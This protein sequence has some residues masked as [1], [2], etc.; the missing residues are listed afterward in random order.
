MLFTREVIFTEDVER[1]FGK[2]KWVS[3]TDE[4]LRAQQKVAEL[5][6]KKDD[7]ADD[8]TVVDVTATE[9]T[10]VSTTASATPPPDIPPVPGSDKKPDG[11]PEG[12]GSAPA[13]DK[14]PEHN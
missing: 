10:N 7:N 13:D 6:A 9:V 4:I 5:T 12:K 2:R 1:I 8:A 14:T 3:R 11:S